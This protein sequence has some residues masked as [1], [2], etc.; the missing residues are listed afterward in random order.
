[1]KKIIFV[2]AIIVIIPSIAFASQTQTRSAQESAPDS[3]GSTEVAPSESPASQ[4]ANQ[5]EV[6]VQNRTNNP[7]T[8]QITEEQSQE[9]VQTQETDLLLGDTATS[10]TQRRSQVAS[11]I[12]S[13]ISAS[14]QI[15]NKGI[16]DQIRNI[17]QEQEKNYED[18]ESKMQ[19]ISSRTSFAKFF[20]GPNYAQIKNAQGLLSQ[21]RSRISQMFQIQTQLEDKNKY[22]VIASNVE[23]LNE[24]VTSLEQ[25][26]ENAQTGFSLF[27]WLAKL[28]NN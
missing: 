16:G 24:Q 8:G 28:L 15:E 17:A 21:Y 6:Q 9:R 14:Y 11:A 23:L 18:I 5:N 3:I 10:Q 7:S 26:I 13:L 27:G 22:Q 2:C 20:I 19:K 1:M 25:E 12:Q 4:S